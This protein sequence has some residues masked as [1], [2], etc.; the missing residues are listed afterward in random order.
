[1]ILILIQIPLVNEAAVRYV[2]SGS[3]IELIDDSDTASRD[4]SNTPIRSRGASDT[5]TLNERL[6]RC[7]A[8]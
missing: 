6:Q 3:D 4:D 5:E 8:M 1:M 7:R 2:I